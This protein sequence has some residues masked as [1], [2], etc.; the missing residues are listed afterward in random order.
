[1]EKEEII[2][3]LKKEFAHIYEW[4]D[5][6]NTEYPKHAHK[7]KVSFYVVDGSIVMNIEGVNKTVTKGERMNVPVG[8]FHTG[9]V[10]SGGCTFIVGEEIEG[11]S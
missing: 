4:T 7:G 10:G 11:D 3:E 6:P 9:K 8:H 2:Q 5:S 1:M